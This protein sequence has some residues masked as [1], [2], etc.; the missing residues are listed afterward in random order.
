M[1]LSLTVVLIA[2]LL[3][4]LFLSSQEF[5]EIQFL[6]AV[7]HDLWNVGVAFEHD[8]RAADQVTYYNNG[9][10]DFTM[11]NSVVDG[12]RISPYSSLLIESKNGAGSVV[13]SAKLKTIS[14]SLTQG[15][16]IRATLWYGSHLPYRSAIWEGSFGIGTTR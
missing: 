5:Q 8:L 15:G 3:P 12:Y 1:S 6:S 14:Y 2:T 7:Q 9:Q 13:V 16:G 11:P 10:I 4:L